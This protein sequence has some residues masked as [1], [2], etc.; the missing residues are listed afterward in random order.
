MYLFFAG[1]YFTVLVCC[2]MYRSALGSLKEKISEGM[3]SKVTK[4][5]KVLMSAQESYN[6]VSNSLRKTCNQVGHYSVFLGHGVG[7]AYVL[8]FKSI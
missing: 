2:V 7:H 3:N 4:R 8:V 6:K 5:N 1:E